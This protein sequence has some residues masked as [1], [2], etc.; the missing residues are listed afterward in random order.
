MIQ[1]C[2]KLD[3]VNDCPLRIWITIHYSSTYCPK[4]IYL[5]VTNNPQRSSETPV[6]P[7]REQ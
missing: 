4:H 6:N 1:N 2:N 5:Q 3:S 7:V